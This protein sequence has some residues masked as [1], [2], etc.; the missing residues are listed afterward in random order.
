M[1][2]PLDTNEFTHYLKFISLGRTD[3]YEIAEP[4]GFDGATFVKEQDSKRYARSIEY[5]SLDKLDFVDAYGEYRQTPQIINPQGDSSNNLDYGLQWLLSIYRE[6]GFESKVEYILKK[7]GAE[8]SY[9]MLDFTEAD[10]TDGYTYVSCKII[11]KTKVADLKRRLDDKFNAF[12]TKNAKQETITPMVTQN[13]LLKGSVIEK[14]SNWVSP[15][16]FDLTTI[17]ADTIGT[18]TRYYRWNNCKDPIADGIADTLTF[19]PGFFFQSE[20]ENAN[21]NDF[22]YIKA[23]KELFNVRVKIS[24][25]T[26]FQ[27]VVAIGSGADGY[28]V[29]R[30]RIFWGSDFDN[31]LGLITI[32][33]DLIDEGQEKT[34]NVN[35]TFIIPYVPAGAYIFIVLEI[36]VRLSSDIGGQVR[37]TNL[38][39]R[40]NIDITVEEKSLNRVIKA[41]RWIDLI[42]QSALFSCGLPIVT[43]L[44][45][46]GGLHY[47]NMVFNRRM[48]NQNVDNFYCTAKTALESVE[49]VNCD[50]EPNETEIFIGHE[51]DF[52]ENLE[53]ANFNIIPSEDFTISENQRVSINKIIYKYKTYEQD[54]TSRNTTLAIHTDSEFLL[55]NEQVENKKELSIE[56]IRDFLSIQTLT[57]LETR[58]PSTS[59]DEDDKVCIVNVE[60]L[61][62][63]SFNEFGIILTQRLF[64]GRLE[65]LNKNISDTGN[66][67]SINWLN[68]GIGLGSNFQITKGSNIGNYTVDT[69]TA[70]VLTLIPLGGISVVTGDLYIN[71]KY[72][73]TNVLLT[74]RTN[75]GFSKGTFMNQAYS[76]KRNLKYF[77]SY[78]K[79]C[80][81]YQKKDIINSYF[82]SNGTYKSQLNTESVPLIE[83]ATI[84]YD[85]LPQPYITPK[86]YNLTAYAEFQDILAY[87]DTYRNNRGFI[88]TFDSNGRVIKGFVKS[89]N[90]NW[91]N[92]SLKLT[93]EELYETEYLMLV[94]DNGI[95]KVNDAP[96]NLQGNSE[97]WKFENEYIK[98]YDNKNRPLSN[99]YKYNFVNLN[100]LIYSSKEDLINA[101]ISL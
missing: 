91:S 42:K 67:Q 45:E 32:L 37:A 72:F 52:Y 46:V 16:V 19:L 97:W 30:F 9:G 3:L 50:Y 83:N 70:T 76:I 87:L 43:E 53:V 96:Y 65:I 77:G 82:K 81:L 75:Q 17:A 27:E 1:N 49:E 73:Y 64:N 84:T 51:S 8:F 13:L 56:F 39:S 12:G 59:T 11:Q 93:I 40:Y 61:A 88:R 80:L 29:N 21:I 89:L 95:L 54:R 28:T 63:S 90:Q 6:F 99:F 69:I 44:F 94:Y 55:Q 2:N 36:E 41:S 101:L 74:S 68:M 85:S 31:R 57:D 92:N 79:S 78:L 98:L 60:V 24:D 25:F 100:G 71:I 34:Y 86:V 48:I 22:K 5:G 47:D 33:D 18:D 23:T 62:P 26:W 38:Q 66:T 4:I 58:E 35:D 7:S 20:V 14:Y 10:I 15:D